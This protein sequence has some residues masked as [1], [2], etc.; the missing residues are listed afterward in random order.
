MSTSEKHPYPPCWNPGCVD[1]VPCCLPAT[2]KF[3]WPELRGVDGQTAKATIEKENPVVTGVIKSPG[4]APF[5][6]ICCNR[7]VIHVDNGGVV[8][9]IPMVG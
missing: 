7:V 1:E 2:P 3:T 8:K 9:S 5:G 6:D 4:D